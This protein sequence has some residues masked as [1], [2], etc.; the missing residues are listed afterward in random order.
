MAEIKPSLDDGIVVIVSVAVSTAR[1]NHQD[2]KCQ[3]DERYNC[4]H[5]TKPH[6]VLVTEEVLCASITQLPVP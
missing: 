6:S 3:E 4:C 1:A 5:G 2:D